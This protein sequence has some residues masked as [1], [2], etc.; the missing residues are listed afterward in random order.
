[1]N[2][3][4]RFH[5]FLTAT[6]LTLALAVQCQAQPLAGFPALGVVDSMHCGSNQ[7][8]LPIQTGGVELSSLG[9][10]HS[11]VLFID[12]PDDPIDSGN[13]NWPVGAGPSYIDDI[14]D[15]DTSVHSGK[16]YNITTYYD[17]MSFNNL[18]VVGHPYYKQAL[19]SLA[20]YKAD[21]TFAKN[22]AYWA[23]RHVLEY[24]DTATEYNVDFTPYDSWRRN[25][26]YNHSNVPDSLVDDIF[27]MWRNWPQAQGFIAQGWSVIGPIFPV[28][29]GKR[30][31]GDLCGTNSLNML[32][33][34]ATFSTPIHEFGHHLLGPGG[35]EYDGG[36]WSV[37]G[38][39]AK[40]TSYCM[41]AFERE[42]LG[43]ITFTDI[44]VD[45][46]TATIPDFAST[47]T[48]YRFTV[49]GYQQHAF[50]IENHQGIAMY[51]VVDHSAS[52][53]HGLYI[54]QLRNAMNT[55]DN[56]LTLLTAD[57]RW[58]W[59]N[60]DSV[61]N[62]WGSQYIP[63]FQRDTVMR[64]NGRTDRQHSRYHKPL[65]STRFNPNPQ[66]QIFVWLDERSGDLMH[67][68]RQVGDGKDHWTTGMM[69]S[70]WSNPS[71]YISDGIIPT[72]F[73]LEVT[74]V[75]GTNIN[76]KFYTTNPENGPPSDPQD[77]RVWAFTD[78][79]GSYPHLTWNGNIEPDVLAGGGYEIWRRISTGSSTFGTWKLID[80][81][82][83]T[84]TE[85]VDREV[86]SVDTVHAMY[87]ANYRIRAY[88]STEKLSTY[89]EERGIYFGTDDS[90]LPG[91]GGGGGCC[92]GGK[93]IARRQSVETAGEVTLWP[94]RPNPFSGTTEIAYSVTRP[95]RVIVDVFDPNGKRVA[96]LVDD[97]EQGA[98]T[99]RV[100]F[101]AREL[102]AG[103]Y[104]C[105]V[106][107]NGNAVAEPITL[108]R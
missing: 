98:G 9:T 72:T 14:I 81:V 90:Q 11:L 8:M 89:S 7:G 30:F 104:I 33:Y 71:S 4:P 78:S 42:R 57:G 62:P 53:G 55:D 70:P 48:A 41:N 58:Y 19:H 43:W 10:I 64:N 47:G 61:I 103:V 101:D 86:D 20:W 28:D 77:L 51:D 105:R 45:G 23:A 39:P 106:I 80:S 16:Q 88:D 107:A 3:I 22:V 79:T 29:S 74:G 35:H 49:P 32:Y 69:F 95:G 13:A 82:S 67:T 73:G 24:I 44:T 84:I 36:L 50:I 52:G 31:I 96:V 18:H 26:I 63:L 12:F 6:L 108:T 60:P 66:H 21:T 25:A 2:A 68:G 38:T 93:I 94:N 17:Q 34:P 59:S 92:I 91:D 65:D 75:S 85:Y 40:N 5:G 102:P 97:V 99:Y 87:S 1:M 76:V 27:I 54:M 37:M 46:T 56:N 15:L 100:T 83:G